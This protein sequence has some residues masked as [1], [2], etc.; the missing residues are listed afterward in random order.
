MASK[1]AT[2]CA[3]LSVSLALVFAWLSP[4]TGYELDIYSDTPFFTWVFIIASMF[5]GA[6]IILHQLFTRTYRQSRLWMLGFGLLIVSRLALLWVPYIRGYLTWDGDN[7]TPWGM[8]LD[9]LKTGHFDVQN[10]YPVVHSFLVQVIQI[11]GMPGGLATNLST[12]LFSAFYII[13]IYLLSTRITPHA[14]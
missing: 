12:G 14:K 5:A 1:I 13:S 9:V 10:A 4:A 8:L 7:I 2:I 3:F 11:T 6:G